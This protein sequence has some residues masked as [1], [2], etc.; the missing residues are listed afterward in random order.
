MKRLFMQIGFFIIQNPF[1]QNFPRGSI[2]EG[3]TKGICAPGLNCYSCP[4][5]AFSCPIGILQNFFR[6]AVS[7]SI[8]FVTGFLVLVGAIFGR[9]VCGFA[10]PMGLLQDLIYKLPTRKLVVRLKF[11]SYLKY[12][13]LVL[14]VIVLPFSVRGGAAFGDPWFCAYICPSGTVFGAWPLVLANDFLRGT[15][16]FLFNFKTAV[17]L[18]LLTAALFINRFFCRVLCPLGAIYSLFN[19]ISFF[20][21]NFNPSK[22]TAC[23]KCNKACQLKLKPIIETTHPDCIRC[24]D[25]VRACEEKA[26]TYGTIKN[27]KTSIEK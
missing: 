18:G 15:L 16:G 6:G 20:R 26:M 22:C 19:R 9:F 7:S 13:V 8:F 23:A 3:R 5:A 2:H 12:A 1:L 25:C 17:A 27:G 11:L 21:I 14:F 10:C 24:G 4:A